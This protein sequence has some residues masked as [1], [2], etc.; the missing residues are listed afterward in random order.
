MA[1]KAW[2]YQGVQG[3]KIQAAGNLGQEHP[4]DIC[5]VFVDQQAIGRRTCQ[6]KNPVDGAI[7][8]LKM[9]QCPRQ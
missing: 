1:N 6:V 7:T 9:I 2:L 8:I 5:T 4:L 3:P